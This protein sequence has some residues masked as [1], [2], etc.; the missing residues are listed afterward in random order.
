MWLFIDVLG[1][2]TLLATT[3]V[4][5]TLHIVKFIAYKE[6]GLIRRQ[7]VKYTAIQSGSG[8]SNIIGVWFLIDVLHYST[9]FSAMFVVSVLFVLRFVF[10]K[11]TGLTVE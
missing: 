4:V 2:Y 1:I 10:F 3:V 9:V 11:L 8:V 7:F 6:I 5:V